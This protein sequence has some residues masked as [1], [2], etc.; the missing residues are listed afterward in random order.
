M[1]HNPIL[2]S[3]ESS[4]DTVTSYGLEGRGIGVLVLGEHDIS[5]I[6]GVPTGSGVHPTAYKMGTEGYFAGGKAAGV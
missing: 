2:R 1:S 3:Q 4:V 5:T 6:H